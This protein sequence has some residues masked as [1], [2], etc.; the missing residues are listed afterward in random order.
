[1]ANSKLSSS[2]A[3]GKTKA[4][5]GWLITVHADMLAL[6]VFCLFGFCFQNVSD[7]FKV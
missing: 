1:M 5:T 2:L 7:Q 3:T 6:F 4:D